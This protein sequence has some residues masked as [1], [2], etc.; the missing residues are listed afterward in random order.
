LIGTG[1][2]LGEIENGTET[3]TH[4]EVIRR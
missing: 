1:I 4:K 3:S 2:Y